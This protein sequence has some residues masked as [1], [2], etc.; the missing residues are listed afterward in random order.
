MINFY[1]KRQLFQKIFACLFK[2]NRNKNTYCIIRVKKIKNEF[3]VYV[4]GNS[5]FVGDNLVF[6]RGFIKRCKKTNK[7]HIALFCENISAFACIR[8]KIMIL[9]QSNIDLP[10]WSSGSRRRPLTAETRVRFP[11]G[12][13]NEKTYPCDMFFSF[14][15]KFRESNGRIS[16]QSC[17]L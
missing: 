13:P 16:S 17:E 11:M 7:A 3:L 5:E 10:S 2:T 9:S 4:G 14:H 8:C 6:R 15:T 12:V 1:Q